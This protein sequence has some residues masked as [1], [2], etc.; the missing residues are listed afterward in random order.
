MLYELGICA[1]IYLYIHTHTCVYVCMHIYRHTSKESAYMCNTVF[2]DVI[3]IIHYKHIHTL[4][5]NV[6]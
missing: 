5:L 1:Y 6:K 4:V 3:I 2:L